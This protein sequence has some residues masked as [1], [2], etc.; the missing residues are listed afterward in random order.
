MCSVNVKVVILSGFDF[1]GDGSTSLEL[2]IEFNL[3]KGTHSAFEPLPRCAR[4]IY[5]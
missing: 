5:P 3:W 2:R 4:Q 1:G